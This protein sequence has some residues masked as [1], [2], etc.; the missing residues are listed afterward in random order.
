MTATISLMVTPTRL[1][2]NDEGPPQFYFLR[3]DVWHDVPLAASTIGKP[4]EVKGSIEA[5]LNTIMSQ[6]GAGPGMGPLPA[7]KAKFMQIWLKLV[8]ER[9]QRELAELPRSD[10]DPPCVMLYVHPTLEWIPWEL[11]HD[12][13][14]FLGLRYV[15]ARVPLVRRGP[16]T[17]VTQHTVARICTFLGEHVMDNKQVAAWEVTFDGLPPT[18]TVERYPQNGTPWPTA[19]MVTQAAGAD[20]LHITCHGGIEDKVFDSVWTLNHQ[21]LPHLYGLGQPVVDQ[22]SF[23]AQ[24]PLVFGNA[25]QSAIGPAAATGLTPGLAYSFFDHGAVAFVGAFAPLSKSL[26]LSFPTTFY[27][28]LLSDGMNVGT[29]LWCTKRDFKAASE[30]DPSWLFYCLYGSPNTQF[31]TD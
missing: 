15:I 26:A 17:S 16:D 9:V 28:H 22:M 6:P 12:G 7:L 25:C 8:P 29:A 21:G 30:D 24:G 23:A 31:V 14:D 1:D 19:D 27:K 2:S 5:V 11:M 10:N 20:I 13:T 4:S 18:V 3:G